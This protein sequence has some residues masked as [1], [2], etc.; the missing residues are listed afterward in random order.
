MKLFKRGAVKSFEQEPAS[1]AE[2]IDTVSKDV[3]V[4]ATSLTR[5]SLAEATDTSFDTQ[6]GAV[7]KPEN[8][9]DAGIITPTK[10][11]EIRAEAI[12]DAI[13]H[14]QNTTEAAAVAAEE[15]GRLALESSLQPTEEMT[16]VDI[17]RQLHG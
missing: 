13:T 17:Q 4:R 7:I 5:R 12:A 14:E 6:T 16:P 1:Q 8:P 11:R 2:K 15:A 10:Y 3:A 9:T